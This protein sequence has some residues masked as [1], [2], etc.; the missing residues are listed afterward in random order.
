MSK[1]KWHYGFYSILTKA[2]VYIFSFTERQL[3]ISTF[4]SVKHCK[5]IDYN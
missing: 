5:E 2:D 4:V 3:F 1:N